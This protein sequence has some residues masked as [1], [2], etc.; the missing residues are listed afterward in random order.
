MEYSSNHKY[1]LI[2]HLWW[3]TVYYTAFCADSL[4]AL[5][6]QKLSPSAAAHASGFIYMPQ[7]C[8]SWFWSLGSRVS[9]CFSLSQLTNAATW[10]SPSYNHHLCVLY[11]A[12]YL[13]SFPWRMSKRVA[14]F[15]MNWGEEQSSYSHTEVLRLFEQRERREEEGIGERREKNERRKLK[16]ETGKL[17]FSTSKQHHVKGS[18]FLD[19][20]NYVA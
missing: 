7:I 9:Y 20:Q 15:T 18:H 8:H 17:G 11:T 12:A 6:R 16:R 5:S 3:K 4:S 14:P 19:Q 1:V 10:H 2:K 13:L